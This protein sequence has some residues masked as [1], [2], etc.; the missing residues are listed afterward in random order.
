MG[1]VDWHQAQADDVIRRHRA[2]S[3]QVRSVAWDDA[4]AAMSLQVPVYTTLDGSELQLVTLLPRALTLGDGPQGA[5]P[6][7][8]VWSA[9]HRAVC[10]MC[11]DRQWV[12]VTTLQAPVRHATCLKKC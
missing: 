7:T 8:A 5:L 9:Q 2:Y 1:R 3:G 10:V 11:A 12:G 6:G 4:L